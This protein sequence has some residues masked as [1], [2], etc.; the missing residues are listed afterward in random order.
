MRI[1]K[2]ID[3]ESDKSLNR[4]FQIDKIQ[5]IDESTGLEIGYI[6][7]GYIPS[8]YIK[9]MSIVDYV[10]D[11][12]GW[13]GLKRSFHNKNYEKFSRTVFN[14]KSWGYNF[15]ENENWAERANE[16]IHYLNEKFGKQF[17]G[18]KEYF[19]DNYYVDYARVNQMFV[20]N[21]YYVK[22]YEEALKL[23]KQQGLKLF[24]SSLKSDVA[25]N[26]F[27]QHIR[28]GSIKCKTYKMKYK[29]YDAM[30]RQEVVEVNYNEKLNLVA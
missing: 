30:E 23:A 19:C 4:G 2:K 1:I 27:K 9:K 28:S 21:G 6:K 7:L 20:G 13:C 14:R 12:V 26:R 8:D 29:Y 16:A 24:T 10:D 15:K 22:L 17:N 5:L 18:F 11:F 25:V 3:S